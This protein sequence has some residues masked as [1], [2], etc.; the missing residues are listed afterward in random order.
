MKKLLLLAVFAVASSV[1]FGQGTLNFANAGAG[2]NAPVHDISGGTP[3]ILTAGSAYSA[4]LYIGPAGTAS[5]SGLST[6]GVS[7]APTPFLSGGQAGYFTGGSRVVSGTPFGS[8]AGS[9]ITVQ[10]RAWATASG[11]SWET[12]TLRGESNLIQ[13]TLTEP[14]TAAPNLVGLTAFNVV[15]EPSSIALG[16]LGLGA[17]ALIRRRK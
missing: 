4:Q 8:A 12:A 1:A 16:L 15:P 11:N 6:N 13:V 14:P 17:V 5:A 9:I 3:G 2:V 10:V 7:G